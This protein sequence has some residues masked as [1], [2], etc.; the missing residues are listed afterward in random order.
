MRRKV[1]GAGG[2]LASTLP[3]NRLRLSADS[4]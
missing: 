2:V 3:A 4:H 1:A